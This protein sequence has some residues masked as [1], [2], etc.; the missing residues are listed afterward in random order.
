MKD[1]QKESGNY[2]V[3]LDNSWHIANYNEETGE[4]KSFT[5]DGILFEDDFQHTF[6]DPINAKR[7]MDSLYKAQQYEL[8]LKIVKV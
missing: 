5:F 4:Y 6:I 2:F 3:K 7:Y 8:I 1:L